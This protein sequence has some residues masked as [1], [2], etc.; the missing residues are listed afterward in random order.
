MWLDHVKQE[1]GDAL[2]IDWRFF[3]LEQVNAPDESYKI[4]EKPADY[5]SR[6]RAAFQAASA[7]RKQGPEAFEHYH[8][9]LLKQRHEA[10]N[11]LRKPATLEAAAA[12]AGLDLDRFREDS[13]DTASWDQI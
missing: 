8:L 13:V 7:A 5:K 1:L 6:G 12:D 9:A 2:Q 3:S 10:G 11:D 4:W